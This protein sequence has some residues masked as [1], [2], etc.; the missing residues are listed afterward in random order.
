M[1][2]THSFHNTAAAESSHPRCIAQ[3]SLRSK[4]YHDVNLSGRK[5]LEYL[6]NK[7]QLRNIIELSEIDTGAQQPVVQA[8]IPDGGPFPLQSL[9]L[10][11]HIQNVAAT[12]NRG[13]RGLAL[14]ARRIHHDTWNGLLC[15]GVPVSLLEL[16]HLTLDHLGLA[17]D[18]NNS[19]KLL[20]CRWKLGWH[21]GSVTDQG[22][23]RHFRGGGVTPST[24]SNYLR[25]DWVETKVTDTNRGVITS[26]LARIICG[27]QIRDVARIT[28]KVFSNVTWETLENKRQDTLVFLLVR[29][30]APHRVSRRRGPKHRPLCPG[31]LRDTHCLWSWAKRP[32]QRPCLTG[33][34]W[35]RNKHF[36][37]SNEE[38]QR[39]RHQGEKNAWYDLI[40]VHDIESYTNV[41]VD[42]DREDAF[43]QS[44]MWC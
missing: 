10:T 27:V 25:G 39:L 41:Q 44:V 17:I 31:L 15:K 35:N 36:F 13:N 2:G 38:S 9:S 18:M 21:V 37:G 22:I 12:L 30:T 24:T 34:H 16:V 7:N 29:Y 32:F 8:V 40:Q 20:G 42:P 19:H 23:T 33:A 11:N 5:M 26:R 43:L 4:T 14:E 6:M 28:S 3:A 1:G